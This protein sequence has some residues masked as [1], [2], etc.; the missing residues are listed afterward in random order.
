[1]DGWPDGPPRNTMFSAYYCWRRNS[2]VS[3][4]LLT[5]N[6]WTFSGL[7]RTC[8]T[9][10]QDYVIA[11]QC[12]ITDKQQLLTLVLKII[13]NKFQDFPGVGSLE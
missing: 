1:M 9:F 12:S 10:F 3:T 8:K 4:L 13:G 6:S 11:Q 5:K 2:R 7:S